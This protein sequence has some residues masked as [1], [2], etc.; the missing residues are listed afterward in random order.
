M[1]ECKFLT[2]SGQKRVRHIQ[3]IAARNIT[4]KDGV[5]SDLTEQKTPSG[6][7]DNTK[8]DALL[9]NTYFTFHWNT[10]DP[11]FYTSEIIS[12]TRN[13]TF[14]LLSKPHSTDWFGYSLNF[15]I[16]RL[17]GKR[18][19][20]KEKD[21]R[22]I[23]EWH[24]DLNLLVKI[25]NSAK[26]EDG[27]Y[28]TDES[29]QNNNK[30]SSILEDSIYSNTTTTNNNNNNNQAKKR[31]Y[32]YNHIIKLNT[33]KDCIFDTKRS[34]NE[35]KN[36]IQDILKKQEDG[37]RF[38]RALN[39][40]K[41]K[42]LELES[43]IMQQKKTNNVLAQRAKDTKERIESIKKQLKQSMIR[44]KSGFENIQ[45]NGVILENNIKMR[46]TM[47]QALN[48][49]RKEL[50]ADLF[51]I[52]PIEQSYDD[53]QQFYIRGVCLPNS[54]YDGKNDESIATALGFTAHL[55]SMLAF[56]LEIPLRY[57]TKPMGSRATVKDLIS[58]I[59]GYREFPLYTKGVDQYRY[60]FGVFLLNKNIEQL[61]NAYGLI[62]MDL[63]HTLPNIH[64]FIQ[65]ILTTSINC[66]P[67]SMS[68]LSI[69]SFANGG[70][71]NIKH[72]EQQEN[73]DYQ[74][75]HH[76]LTL[77]PK[78]TNSILISPSPSSST[79]RLMN[80]TTR[81]LNHHASTTLLSAPQPMT[82][83]S[84]MDTVTAS[85]CYHEE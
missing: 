81:S 5:S 40:H 76:L 41:N 28:C 58:L 23:V 78:Q 85:S 71:P 63:R 18:T 17:W 29:V 20:D 72:E 66:S 56:Y 35:V 62:V 38:N 65:A 36:D 48:R 49:R 11:A 75:C 7:S 74:G 68:V 6:S 46:H 44:C 64:Y 51:C 57:P 53:S 32:T 31:S 73:A 47:F 45:E 25:G 70:N 13:P 8:N 83:T 37:L 42:L 10:F 3:S 16:I 69:S 43:K 84:V 55:V 14:R 60:E 15:M 9:L 24:L 52:Y 34:S 27:F 26:L 67:T 30:R 39:Q 59:S 82:A 22:L 21:Y 77:Q 61:M 4:W 50:I 19:S 12:N 33:L 2:N 54:S 1:F 79:A 80:R